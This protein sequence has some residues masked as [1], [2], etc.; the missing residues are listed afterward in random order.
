MGL[1]SN[2]IGEAI[3]VARFAMASTIIS[4]AE[5]GFNSLIESEKK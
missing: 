2:E 1:T 3:L 4:S 5:D